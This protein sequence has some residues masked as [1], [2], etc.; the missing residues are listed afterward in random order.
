[1]AFIHQV[2]SSVNGYD[3]VLQLA[4]EEIFF[5]MRIANN[6]SKL[7][8]GLRCY[9]QL[10]AASEDAKQLTNLN[11]NNQ[12]IGVGLCNGTQGF[13]HPNPTDVIALY[14][15]AGD[16]VIFNLV[17]AAVP[18]TSAQCNGYTFFQ[19]QGNTP[20]HTP[21]LN[22]VGS[23][24]VRHYNT[25]RIFYVPFYYDFDRVTT[26]GSLVVSVFART[27]AQ[28]ATVPNTTFDTFMTGMF[29][30]GTPAS[31][32]NLGSTVLTVAYTGTLNYFDTL[33]VFSNCT[34]NSVLEIGTLAVA[35]FT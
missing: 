34:A 5:P 28:V 30:N 22:S 21:K 25:G 19:N 10:I 1:M 14:N 9:I 33:S 35:R 12:R 20:Q 3:K 2:Y 31:T 15:G 18:Y 24:T 13:L 27:A 16:G 32:T 7:R 17:T 8:I 29:T 23:F 4:G 6:W 11:Y 26:P